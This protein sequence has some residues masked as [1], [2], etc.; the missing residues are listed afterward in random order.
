M[1]G[2]IK[3]TKRNLHYI[4]EYSCDNVGVQILEYELINQVP[5]FGVLLLKCQIYHS[6]FGRR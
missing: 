5:V 4:E 2:F 6:E 3:G 1:S